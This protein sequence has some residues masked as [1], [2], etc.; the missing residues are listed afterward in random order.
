MFSTMYI[1]DKIE[2]ATVEL[3][4]LSIITF[5]ILTKGAVAIIDEM[6]ATYFKASVS[7]R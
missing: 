4:K 3:I 2:E 5:Y 7:N 1:D 6:A